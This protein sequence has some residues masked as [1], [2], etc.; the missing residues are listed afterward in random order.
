[1][2]LTEKGVTKN[3]INRQIA[4]GFKLEYSDP[5][6]GITYMIRTDLACKVMRSGEIVYNK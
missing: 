2:K 6:T 1:M 3:A 4:K 5:Q